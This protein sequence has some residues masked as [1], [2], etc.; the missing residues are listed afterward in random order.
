MTRFHPAMTAAEAA[1]VL[2]VADDS[3]W[4]VVRGAYRDQI[5]SHHPD[6][7]GAA[8]AD[9]AAR[10]IEAFRV[11]DHAHR[12]GGDPTPEPAPTAPPTRPV[13]VAR[14]PPPD[15]PAPAVWR[16]DGDSLQLDAPAEETFRWLFEAAHDI[17]EITYVDRSV[18]IMEVLCQFEGEPATSLLVTLQGRAAGTEVFCTA[19]SIEAR[20]APPVESVVDLLEL[21]LHR[22]ARP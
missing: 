3:E 14:W 5:R 4:T 18:P 7:A 9:R 21:A 13:R 19:E 6:R 1:R 2:G 10:I 12:H 11:L 16:T 8:S 20:P 22:R 17:G 15:G